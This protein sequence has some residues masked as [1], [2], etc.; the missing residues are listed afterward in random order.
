MT[1]SKPARRLHCLV[2]CMV[3]LLL[4]ACES[5]NAPVPPSKPAPP[6]P[7]QQPCTSTP[8][9][10]TASGKDPQEEAIDEGQ[11]MTDALRAS[12]NDRER[13]SVR[14]YSDS[15]RPDDLT[16]DVWLKPTMTMRLLPQ[17]GHLALTTS[18][19]NHV[20]ELTTPRGAD[21]V[22][23]DYSLRVLE[24]S[25]VH[26]L[27]EMTCQVFEY[28]PNRFSGGVTYYLYDQPTGMMRE[29]WRAGV[30][31]KDD[32]LP[33]AEPRPALTRLDNGYQFD[34]TGVYPGSAPGEHYELHNRFTRK[35]EGKDTILDC[36]NVAPGA[37]SEPEDQ[38]TC[39]G[40]YLQRVGG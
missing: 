15:T 16:L 9:G 31:E 6:A 39:E 11:R 21:G 30:S 36:T 38:S 1:P 20:F 8:C 25:D 5:R 28:R 19:S 33:F 26:V 34:W 23:P 27:L 12:S 40:A 4:T 29:I 22:C 7:V 17:E 10:N 18:A 14:I 3:A 32:R 13:W 37:T 35:Q 2:T 24:A